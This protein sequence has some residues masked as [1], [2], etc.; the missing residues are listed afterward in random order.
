MTRS[1]PQ[2]ILDLPSEI[3]HSMWAAIVYLPSKAVAK[4]LRRCEDLLDVFLP[5]RITDFNRIINP[6]I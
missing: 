1:W 4:A 3:L 2:R 5:I 6:S